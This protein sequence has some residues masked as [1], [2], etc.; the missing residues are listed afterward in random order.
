MSQKNGHKRS[1]SRSRIKNFRQQMETRFE[2]LLPKSS[3]S[4]LLLR[5]FLFQSFYRG[6]FLCRIAYWQRDLNSVSLLDG[7]CL[8]SDELTLLRKAPTPFFEA[9]VLPTCLFPWLRTDMEHS[10]YTY[11]EEVNLLMSKYT[12][13]T[14]HSSYWRSY[15]NSDICHLRLPSY[16]EAGGLII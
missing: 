3:P 6:D 16:S 12:I 4:S 5:S 15:L 13:K 11:D 9:S 8:N 14:F 7:T 2:D 10:Y 1:Q